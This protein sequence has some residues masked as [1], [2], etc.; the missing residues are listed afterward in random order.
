MGGESGKVILWGAGGQVLED[1]GMVQGY[2][3][4]EA[5]FPSCVPRSL[6]KCL[7]EL[8]EGWWG[9]GVSRASRAISYCFLIDQASRKY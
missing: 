8:S 6:L 7:E 5:V 3:H 9:G 2:R 1:N 4:P